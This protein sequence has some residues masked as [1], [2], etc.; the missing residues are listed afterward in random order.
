MNICYIGG[1]SNDLRCQC[2]HRPRRVRLG[3]MRSKFHKVNCLSRPK[4]NVLPGGC[5]RK[6]TIRLLRSCGRGR[7]FEILYDQGVLNERV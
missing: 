6:Q 5:S 3:L 7:Y 4:I 1:L 2:S